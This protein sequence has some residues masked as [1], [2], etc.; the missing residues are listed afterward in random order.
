MVLFMKET[1]KRII[2]TKRATKYGLEGP[3]KP[4]VK[5]LALMKLM[6][7]VTLFRPVSMLFTEPIVLLL[8]LYNSF[9]FSVLFTDFAAYPYTLSKVYHFNTWQ[10]GLG[11]LGILAG[12]MLA[13]STAILL[14]RRVFNRKWDKALK[15]GKAA[16]APE[17][18][19]YAAML[20]SF[21]VPIGL[22][23]FA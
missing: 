23:W 19:L 14:D 9:T 12:F 11:F 7:T 20:G 22:F 13:T 5:G 3:P 8:S 18:R 15:D 6:L 21:G 2:L 1:Y 17:H 10:N 4:P 16:A